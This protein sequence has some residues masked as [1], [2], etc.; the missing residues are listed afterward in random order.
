MIRGGRPL[1]L[2]HPS[3]VV[4]PRSRLGQVSPVLSGAVINPGADV[5]CN[6]IINIFSSVDHD[7]FIGDH[8]N[9]CPGVS[10]AGSV[11]V[12]RLSMIRTGSCVISG[13][14]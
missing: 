12:G 9:L 10:V 6:V 3:A 13:E 4:S 1:T 8:S 5:G 2:I 14:R 7:S 11:V